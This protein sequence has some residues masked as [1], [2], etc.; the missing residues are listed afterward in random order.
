MAGRSR[1]IGFGSGLGGFHPGYAKK[2]GGAA[3]GSCAPVR[4]GG[5][6]RLSVSQGGE[7]R[8]CQAMRGLGQG[9][10][11]GRGRGK[12]GAGRAGGRGKRGLGLDPRGF[13]FFLFCFIFQ[14]PFPKRVL[15]AKK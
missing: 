8:A 9:K 1:G 10:G 3:G 11:V 4:E 13:L 5:G 14:K 7:G 2:K 6:V 12:E 15:N